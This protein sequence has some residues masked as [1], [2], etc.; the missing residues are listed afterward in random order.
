MQGPEKLLGTRSH[1]PQETT[2]VY[3]IQNTYML[4]T[5]SFSADLLCYHSFPRSHTLC[6]ASFTLLNMEYF[7][8]SD[9]KALAE[10]LIQQHHVPGLT[11]AVVD[12]DIT[13]LSAYGKAQL[14]PPVPCTPDT[15]FDIAS[16]SKSFTAAAIG[17]LVDDREK[18]PDVEFSSTMSSLLPEDFIMPSQGYTDDITLDDVLGHMTG[19]GRWAT[20]AS[21][22]IHYRLTCKAGTIYRT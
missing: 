3:V 20:L 1:K 14:D 22:S 19:M 17:M 4:L 15:L 5:R 16:C 11:I 13:S 10:K 21:N 2:G 6:L 12:N 8:S 18:Y 9:F 7:N